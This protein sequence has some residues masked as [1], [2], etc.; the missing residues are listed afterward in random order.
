LTVGAHIKERDKLNA[1]NG[2]PNHEPNWENWL[3][4]NRYELNAMT[5]PQRVAWV[6]R[7]FADDKLAF[8]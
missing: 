3:Q 8:R 2:N 1:K 6:E 5:S 7:K 4:D